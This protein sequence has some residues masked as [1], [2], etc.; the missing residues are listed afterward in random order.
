M[1]LNEINN[2]INIMSEYCQ[3]IGPG[4]STC[5]LIIGNVE[6]D[7]TVSYK[8]SNFK[9]VRNKSYVHAIR[10]NIALQLFEDHPDLERDGFELYPY[11][12][13]YNERLRALRRKLNSE[14][15]KQYDNNK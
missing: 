2:E 10:R 11:Y 12:L 4:T 15:K 9:I 7:E 13:W 5:T 8:D 14:V 6:R 1:K 3:N